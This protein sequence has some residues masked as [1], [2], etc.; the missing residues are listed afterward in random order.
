MQD[1]CEG[2]LLP[3]RA[4]SPFELCEMLGIS[5]STLY[6]LWADGSGPAYAE[7]GRRRRVTKEALDSWLVSR[8][9]A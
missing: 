8:E 9:V 4:F 6:R 1:Q 2:K 7:I 3:R 5:R